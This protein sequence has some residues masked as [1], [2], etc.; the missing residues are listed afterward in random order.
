M[1]KK[2]TGLYSWFA[3]LIIV[4]ALLLSG[5]ALAKEKLYI[6]TGH[7]IPNNIIAAFEQQNPDIEVELLQYP[8]WEFDDKLLVLFMTGQRM[9]LLV[10]WS[11]YQ[12][13]SYALN[14]QL[15]DLTPY[16]ERDRKWF[17]ESRILPQA[18]ESGRIGNSLAGINMELRMGWTIFYNDQLLQEAGLARP[19]ARWDDPKWNWQTFEQY[20]QKLAKYDAAG[21]PVQHGMGHYDDDL[22]IFNL[23]WMWDTDVFA[24]EAYQTGYAKQVYLAQQP[25]VQAFETLF[26]TEKLSA[27]TA[28]KNLFLQ[29]K[30]GMW[31]G[32]GDFRDYSFPWGATR[33]PI[34]PAGT[35]PMAAWSSFLGIPSTAENVEG[36]WKFIKFMLTDGNL[37]RDDDGQ[38]WRSGITLES[39]QQRFRTAKN[40][41]LTQ[42]QLTDFYIQGLT[43]YTRMSPRTVIYGAGEVS[44]IVYNELR[45]NTG[46]TKENLFVGAA[47][48]NA[49]TRVNAKLAE[50]Y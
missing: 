31:L 20:A 8:S 10:E 42:N 7:P 37:M 35:V 46:V 29:G 6:A 22:V 34:G 4:G 9:D 3:V 27:N 43:G 14:G 38:W 40:S 13:A 17:E 36:A 11:V 5:T 24:Q 16:L 23:A 47:M 30:V 28:N 15:L 33:A 44:S 12:W 1:L 25:L 50:M 32:V 18:Y 2:S 26:A 45:K 21:I 41:V 19:P 39:W 49:Q 48:Q